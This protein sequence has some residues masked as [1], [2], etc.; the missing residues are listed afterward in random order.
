[1]IAYLGRYTHRIAVSEPRLIAITDTQVRFRVRRG[2]DRSE[3][4][5]VTL[6]GAEF[7]HRFLQHVLPAG[8]QRLL[9][10]GLKASRCKQVMLR[11]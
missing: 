2:A 10:Y 9:H 3:R 8:A 5:V 6:P 7:L 1:V 4:K 11:Q